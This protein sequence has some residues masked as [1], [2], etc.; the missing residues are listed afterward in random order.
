MVIEMVFSDHRNNSKTENIYQYYKNNFV[1]VMIEKTF[2]QI[3]LKNKISSLETSEFFQR[4]GNKE[5]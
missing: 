5:S 2:T 3:Y 1:I 4:P